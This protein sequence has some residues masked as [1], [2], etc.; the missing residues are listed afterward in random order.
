MDSQTAWNTA[1]DAWREFVRSGADYY[2]LEVHGPALL[3]ACA[4][5]AGLRVL[6]LGCGEGYF[7]RAL[8]G[9]GAI[10]TALDI[11]EEQLRSAQEQ[12]RSQPLG[13]QYLQLDARAIATRW[14]AESFDLVTACMSL[15]DMNAAELA[16]QGAASI[17]SDGGR[18]VFS[19]PHPCTDTPVREWERD[20]SRRKLALKIDRYFDTGESVMHWNM[21]RLRYEWSSPFWRRTLQQWSELLSEAGFLIR[22]LLEPRPT[23]EQVRTNPKLDDCARLPYFLV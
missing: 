7:S 6:D 13:L 16:V 1:A 10:V 3:D 8:A 5:L 17:L 11:S 23:V 15:Q 21:P 20:A 4:P 9:R 12:E 22:R 18:L 2:R 19:V 14:P